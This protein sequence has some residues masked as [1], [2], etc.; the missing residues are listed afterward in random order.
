MAKDNILE[1]IIARASQRQDDKIG[2]LDLETE[3]L[4][5]IKVTLPPVRDILEFIENDTEEDDIYA[6]LLTNA[7]LVYENVPLLKN[8]YA[9]LSDAYE[10]KDPARLTLKIFETAQAIGELNS[11]ADYITEAY[12]VGKEAI[13]N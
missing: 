2:I 10:E 1:T 11:I 7:S 12:G 8:N 6:G 13:K 3:T 4:G 9:K 5:H